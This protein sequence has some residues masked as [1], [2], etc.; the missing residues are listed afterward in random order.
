MHASMV[1]RSGTPLGFMSHHLDRGG[2]DKNA[3]ERKFNT[4]TSAR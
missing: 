3:L 2:S 1:Y 4:R